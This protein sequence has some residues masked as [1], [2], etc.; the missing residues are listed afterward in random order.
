[1]IPSIPRQPGSY[2]LVLT[3]T[4]EKDIKVGSLGL[5]KF[6]S[7]WYAYAGSAFGPGGL[8]ARLGRHLEPVCKRHWHIDFLRTEALVAEAWV[9]VG[10][11]NR[12]HLWACLLT[13]R[14]W[15]GQGVSGFGSSDCRCPSHLVHFHRRPQIGL[16][17]GKWGVERV[18]F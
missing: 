7:G 14:P 16:F 5:L 17:S 9:A 11:P 6:P 18:R 8:S 15:N 10:P 2:L 13:Q 1:M 12:E 3:L 4:A